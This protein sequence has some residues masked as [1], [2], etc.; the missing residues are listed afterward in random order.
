[1][2][3]FLKRVISRARGHFSPARVR[4]LP[5]EELLDRAGVPRSAP[6]ELLQVA[7]LAGLRLDGEGA[8]EGGEGGGEGSGEGEGG[9]SGEPPEPQIPE[10]KVLAD[11]AE[12]NRLRR[13]VSDTEKAEK[14]RKREE[15][16]AADDHGAV[17]KSLEEE[18]DEKDGR[19]TELESELENTRK[20]QT[21]TAV[22]GRL[23]FNDPADALAFLPADT[24]NDE[25]SIEKALKKVA[26]EK[27]YLVGGQGSRTGAP[28][29]GGEPAPPTD[30]DAA[31]AKAEAD[32]DVALSTRLKRQ[33]H[34][35]PK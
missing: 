1:M 20:G 27:A 35:T 24:P 19:I 22:A 30:I 12:L 9:G 13:K 7:Q 25:A 21:V 16:E 18:S 26:E 4:A 6:P 33:K 17:V 8:G 34:L 5:L 14:K 15:A 10:G 3:S 28:G 23:K 11:E 2:F 29:G 31:I 32:K